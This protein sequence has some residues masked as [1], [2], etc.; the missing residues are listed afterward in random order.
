MINIRREGV[1]IEI[2]DLSFENDGVMNPAVIA[3]GQTVHLFYRAVR[4]GNHSTIGYCRLDGPLKVVQRD[5]KPL[6]N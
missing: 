6:I 3:E 5:E 2:T 4:K 1:I